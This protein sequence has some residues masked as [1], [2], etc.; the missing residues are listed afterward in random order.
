MQDFMQQA[1]NA[2]RAAQQELDEKEQRL[3]DLA[4]AI[5]DLNIKI[6]NVLPLPHACVQ[7]LTFPV[8][9]CLYWLSARTMAVT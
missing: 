9:C 6:L 1:R 3:V 4:C 8:Q 5:N 7:P 2:A